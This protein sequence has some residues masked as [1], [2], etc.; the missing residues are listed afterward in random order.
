VYLNIFR[1]MAEAMA[2]AS[3][4]KGRRFVGGLLPDRSTHMHFAPWRLYRGGDGSLRW[5]IPSTSP[6]VLARPSTFFGVDERAFNN[7]L[8]AA[9]RGGDAFHDVEP[10]EVPTQTGSLSLLRDGTVLGPSNYFAPVDVLDF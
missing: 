8:A 2:R 1:S 5:F 9:R 7:L 6:F 3:V 10:T 4:T